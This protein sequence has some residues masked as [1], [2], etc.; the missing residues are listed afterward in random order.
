MLIRVKLRVCGSL[1]SYSP[2]MT[3]ASDLNHEFEDQLSANPQCVFFYLWKSRSASFIELTISSTS[4]DNTE[5]VIIL[6]V[7]LFLMIISLLGF[8]FYLWHLKGSNEHAQSR[9]LN[10]LNGYLSVACMGCSPATLNMIIYWLM[11]LQLSLLDN[12]GKKWESVHFFISVRVLMFHIIAIAGIFLLISV[13]TVINHFKPGLY[14]HIS[15]AWRQKIAIPVLLFTFV[16]IENFLLYS[17]PSYFDRGVTRCYIRRSRTMVMIPATV[18]SFLCQI[19]VVVDDVWGWKK[20]YDMVRRFFSPNSVSPAVNGQTESVDL[21]VFHECYNPTHILNQHAEFV[22]LSTGFLCICL[23][24]MIVFFISILT[25]AFEVFN[26]IGPGLAWL[27]AMA[28]TPT[29]WIIRSKKMKEKFKEMF[30]FG[31][32]G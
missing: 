16:L 18:V 14:L 30:M 4:V 31:G 22:S 19:V 6:F 28:V 2:N 26:F 10:I 20:F 25:T 13:A 27:A 32:H 3:C 29:L 11:F 15:I 12:T 17:S 8:S 9:L 5:A 7:G 23:F 1:F 21:S 24:N